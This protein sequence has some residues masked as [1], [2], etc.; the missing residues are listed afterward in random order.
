[1]GWI[2]IRVF[3]VTPLVLIFAALI[4]LTLGLQAIF[5]GNRPSTELSRNG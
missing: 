2:L 5:G 1:M 4:L 3:L